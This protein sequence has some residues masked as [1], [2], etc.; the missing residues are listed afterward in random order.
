MRAYAGARGRAAWYV[1]GFFL[2]FVL[3]NQANGQAWVPEKG[4]GD[5]SLVYQNLYTRDHFLGDSSRL[6]V[7]GIRLVGLIHSVDYGLTDKF[8]ARLSLPVGA[9]KYSGSSPHQLP[10]DNGNYHGTL[11]DLNLGLRY[12]VRTRPLSLTPFFRVTI[13]T[14]HYEHFA[15]SAVGSQLREFQF[16]ISVGRQ[17]GP[18]LPNA[19]FQGGYS[20]GF[21]QRILGIRPMRSRLDGEFGYFLGRRLQARAIVLSQISHGGLNFPED[22]PDRT[23]TN[24]RWRHHDQISKIDI[25]NVGGGLSFD[26]SK[27]WTVFSSLLTS[28]WG[29]NGHALQT[30]LTIGVSW[31]FRTPLAERPAESKNQPTVAIRRFACACS[32]AK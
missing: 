29:R 20:F 13:P 5:F 21:A 16:G 10:I 30:G 3:A 2:L 7:G 32:T 23:P 26:L 8:A 12:N 11:Q 31:S 15:H 27:S 22:Y 14:R 25:L 9:G 6:A 18:A 17:L 1:C 28:V 4:T 24:E 19:Y